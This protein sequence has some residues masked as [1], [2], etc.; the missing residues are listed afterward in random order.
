MKGRVRRLHSPDI[1]LESGLDMLGDTFHFLVQAMIGPDD[2]DGDDSFSFE[3]CSP[4]WMAEHCQES[5]AQWGNGFLILPTA[6]LDTIFAMVEE[7]VEVSEGKDWQEIAHKIGKYADWEFEGY[8][9][10]EP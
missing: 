5:G 6:K 4:K 8:K 7:V 3:V 9:R 1:D 2:E 10:Y